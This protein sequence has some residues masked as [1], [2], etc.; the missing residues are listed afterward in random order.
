[1]MYV[2]SYILGSDILDFFDLFKSEPYT[3]II[4]YKEEEDGYRYE[5]IFPG[6]KK[7]EILL[8]SIIIH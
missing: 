8:Y 1:M 5:L 7:E 6:F 3:S 4:D 2:N